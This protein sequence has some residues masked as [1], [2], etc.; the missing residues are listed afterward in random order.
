VRLMLH[1]WT[2][3]C[4]A[5]SKRPANQHDQRAEPLPA[6]ARHSTQQGTTWKSVY[7]ICY[8]PNTVSS[9]TFPGK[10]IKWYY[11][12]LIWWTSLLFCTQVFGLKDH[13]TSLAQ[14]SPLFF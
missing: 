7:S 3:W 9:S 11:L 4:C 13:T 10:R 1:S 12:T 2:S 8:L 14:Q 6:S 5:P